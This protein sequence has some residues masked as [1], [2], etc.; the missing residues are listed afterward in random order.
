M[1][2][3]LLEA[4]GGVICDVHSEE[5]VTPETPHLAPEEL[6]E[7]NFCL[8]VQK[9]LLGDRRPTALTCTL[10]INWRRQSSEFVAS[11]DAEDSVTTTVLDIPRF[12]VPMGEPRVLASATPSS[13][14]A[15]LIHMD[16]VL[17]NPSTHFLTFNLVM[18]ASEHF[19]FSGPKT[20]VVQLVPLSRH[21]V[22]FN[23]FAAKRGL[24][25]QPQLVVIDTYFN[26]TLR[27]LPTGDMRSDKKGVLVW[28]DADD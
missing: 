24:W 12:V 16:Y 8:D 3:V 28:V 23:L 1:S 9:L 13:S 11:S 25:I 7:S 19:A 15:G 22:N 14:M 26:K 2:L 21:T 4:N 17:E 10:E 5:P 27:V 6:R 18:E 20:T